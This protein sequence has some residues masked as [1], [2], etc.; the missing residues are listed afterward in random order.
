MYRP[1]IFPLPFPLWGLCLKVVMLLLPISRST[2]KVPSVRCWMNSMKTRPN[3][4]GQVKRW[5]RF[6]HGQIPRR[7]FRSD[8]DMLQT[9]PMSLLN[10]LMKRFFCL[11][12]FARRLVSY[13]IIS[14][15]WTSFDQTH[16]AE[17]RK[18]PLPGGQVSGW[19]RRTYGKVSRFTS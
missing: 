15:I 5:K 2:R 19:I 4:W 12:I 9:S 13:T 17:N 7:V 3:N 18:E 14:E 11:I 10:K 6:L 8:C 1:H 16:S